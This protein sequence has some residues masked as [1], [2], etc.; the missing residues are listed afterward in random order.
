M[1]RTEFVQACRDVAVKANIR[2]KIKNQRSKRVRR[3]AKYAL[4]TG[5][6]M[7]VYSSGAYDIS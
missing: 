5:K 1:A 7:P 6:P 3:D 4:R 2:R